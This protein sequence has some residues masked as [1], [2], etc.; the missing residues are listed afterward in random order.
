MRLGPIALDLEGGRVFAEIVERND[1]E[2]QSE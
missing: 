2:Q 1:E